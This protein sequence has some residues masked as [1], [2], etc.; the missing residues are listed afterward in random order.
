[1]KSQREKPR[2]QGEMSDTVMGSFT[3]AA[4]PH[5]FAKKARVCPVILVR[6]LVHRVS[7]GKAQLTFILTGAQKYTEKNIWALGVDFQSKTQG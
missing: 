7:K 2:V 1:M 3:E 4:L 5:N 6:K